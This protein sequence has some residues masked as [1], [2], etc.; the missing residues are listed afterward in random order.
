MAFGVGVASRVGHL[1]D[2]RVS[3]P[4]LSGRIQVSHTPSLPN[5]TFLFIVF[6]V[7]VYSLRTLFRKCN[8]ISCT[9]LVVRTTSQEV[10]RAQRRVE[11]IHVHHTVSCITQCHASRS[12]MHHAASCI[13]QR[14]ASRSVMHH[15][16]SCITQR[17][18][19]RSVMHHTASC[20]T[21]RHV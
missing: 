5:A 20:I 14:H 19:S 15:A 10:Y 13:T 12:V 4:R 3:V 18:A 7:I 11:Y 21:Q 1:R 16:A 9:I 2:S 8:N 17:H 6:V